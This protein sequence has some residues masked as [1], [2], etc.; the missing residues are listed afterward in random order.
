M[1]EKQWK[2]ET[3]FARNFGVFSPSDQQTL[4][5]SRVAIAGM[6]GVGGVHALG[7]ARLGIGKFTIADPDTFEVANF[8]RQFGADLSTVGRAKAVVMKERI[9]SIN[10]EADVRMFQEPV[11][12]ENL[13]AFLDGADLYV[14]G[15]D[16]YVVEARRLIFRAVAEKGIW[17]ITAGPLSLS[18]GWILFDPNGMSFDRYFDFQDGMSEL[19]SF[20]A[21][22]AG[23]GPSAL[24]RAYTDFSY[25]SFDPPNGP[26]A[27]AGC[28]LAAGVVAAQAAKILLK[29]PG[30][31][32]APVYHQFD[33]YRG[34]YIKRRLWGGNRNPIQRIKRS[35]IKRHLSKRR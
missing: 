1:T 31:D 8:N 13:S 35:I 9:L 2:Y 10:P 32:P 5:Q 22:I 16:A 24:H 3:A 17:A 6:G 11:G 29:R 12:R 19:D 14:D 15:V 27:S 25:F 21:F 26:S 20:T 28:L 7:L 23:V 4:R 33:A 18:T 30:L 34:R